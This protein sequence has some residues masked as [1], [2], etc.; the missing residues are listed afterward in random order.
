MSFKIQKESFKLYRGD[1]FSFTFKVQHEG[2]GID[3]SKCQIYLTVKER[4]TDLDTVLRLDL[5]KGI[6][7][8]E[9][10]TLLITFSHNDT[11]D[12][13]IKSGIYDLQLITPNGIRKT[14]LRGRLKLV[15]DVGRF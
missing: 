15:H 13:E 1:D 10:D 5:D 9:R 3:I 2:S 7:L 8:L 14:I 11:K 4:L 12:L 6:K